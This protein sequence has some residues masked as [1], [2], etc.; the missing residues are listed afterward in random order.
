MVFHWRM[1]HWIRFAPAS[2]SSECSV[3]HHPPEKLGRLRNNSVRMKWGVHLFKPEKFVGCLNK[4]YFL[5]EFAV[6]SP[7]PEYPW[8]GL[9]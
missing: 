3:Y 9:T 7:K 8:S 2:I 6:F 1:P 4:L 5:A